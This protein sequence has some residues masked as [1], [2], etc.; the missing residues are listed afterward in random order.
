MVS[1]PFVVDRNDGSQPIALAIYGF[2]EE[3][4]ALCG[5]FMPEGSTLMIGRMD[6]EDI[7]LTAET[8]TQKLLAKEDLNGI[9][10]WP[11]LGRNMVLV[12]DPMAE[13]DIVRQT[14]ADAVPWHLAYSGG[15]CCPVYFK[16]GEIVNRFHNFTFVGLAF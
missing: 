5:G 8:S 10:A 1:V 2:D 14:I 11:C 9:I 15:E 7:L 13:I 4:S 16:D 3:G 6:T 12:M